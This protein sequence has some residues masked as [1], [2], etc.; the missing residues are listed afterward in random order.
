[1]RRQLF[2]VWAC[3]LLVVGCGSGSHTQGDAGNGDDVLQGSDSNSQ[4]WN[5]NVTV[6]A[7]AVDGTTLSSSTRL[8]VNFSPYTDATVDHY[9]VTAREVESGTLL[10]TVWPVQSTQIAL[11]ELRSDTEYEITVRACTSAACSGASLL[12]TGKGRTAKEVWRLVGTGN[13]L[14]GVTRIVPNGNVQ[15]HA[16]RFGAWAGPDYEGKVQLY[17]KE[18]IDGAAQTTWVKVAVT[19]KVV[20]DVSTATTF[21]V[22][23]NAGFLQTVKEPIAYRYFGSPQGV[24]MNDGGGVRVR[25]FGEPQEV[26]VKNRI[27]YLDSQDAL[28]R[29]FHPG[30]ETTCGATEYEDGQPC[31]FTYIIGPSDDALN[32][33]PKLFTTR[34]FKMVYPTR[35]DSRWDA[36]KG[37]A[38]FVSTHPTDDAIA[39]GEWISNSGYFVWNGQKW[40]AQYGTD[41]C[42]LMQ[43]EVQAPSPLHLG[44]T[45]YKLYF[46]RNSVKKMN[47]DEGDKP[48][49]VIYGDASR[50]GDPNVLDFAD[51][52]DSQTQARHID[53]QWPDGSS[54]PATHE[55]R[56]DDYA[57]IMPSNDPKLQIMYSNIASP[58]DPVP[59]IGAL[60]LVNP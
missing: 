5:A 57:H 10:S 29:D 11:D 4:T 51:W 42:P 17:Y 52:E 19:S 13:T 18:L 15:S 36:A 47:E 40:E 20:T 43:K 46:T 45:R 38:M 2:C 16:F 7:E 48:L 35:P 28:G 56:L 55:S 23:A 8:R 59:F 31:A 30:T 14:S 12:A 49:M 21:E 37:T 6:S 34:Q 44:G 26:S 27:G 1:M 33:N 54:F 25:L 3:M 39:C 32:P 58:D 9:E 60:F 22:V 24:P 53:V 50:T 41:G